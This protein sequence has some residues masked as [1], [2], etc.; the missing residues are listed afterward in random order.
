MILIFKIFL[1][2]FWIL[3]VWS[4]LFYVYVIRGENNIFFIVFVVIKGIN[5]IEIDML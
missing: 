1:F 3:G 4:F 2:E 5:I